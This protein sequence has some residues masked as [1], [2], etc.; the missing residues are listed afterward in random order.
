MAKAGARRLAEELL[1]NFEWILVTAR[2]LLLRR[3]WVCGVLAE[4]VYLPLALVA[5]NLIWCGGETQPPGDA[6]Q[7]S[8]T[9]PRQ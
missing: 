8:A 6:R 7:L 3:E 2:P 5:Q 4:V 9:P 1:K